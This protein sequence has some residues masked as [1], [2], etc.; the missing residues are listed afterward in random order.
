MQ[1]E[2][3]NCISSIFSRAH[4]SQVTDKKAPTEK[5]SSDQQPAQTPNKPDAQQASKSYPITPTASPKQ[6]PSTTKPLPTQMLHNITTVLS[7]S[8]RTGGHDKLKEVNR[9]IALKFFFL[10][11]AL[12]R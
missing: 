3:V 9:R 2:L 11:A 8:R 6:A 1:F 4:S 12:F 5:S 10:I 7:G